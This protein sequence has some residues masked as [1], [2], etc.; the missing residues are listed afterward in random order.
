[1][2]N[3]FFGLALIAT[4]LFFSTYGQDLP[5]NSGTSRVKK[6]SGKPNIPGNFVV[7]LGFNQPF[8][9]D[10][11]FSLGFWGSRTFNAYYQY[12]IRILQSKF[13][14][15]PGIGLSLERFKLKNLHR[16]AYPTVGTEKVL[17]LIPAYEELPEVKKS[18]IVAN[19]IDVPLE[20]RFSTR[21]DDP[22]RS[23]KA[24]VGGRIGYLYDAFNKI[25]YKEEGE[26]KVIKDKQ[27][28]NLS[29]IRYGAFAKVGG[30][31]FSVF[32]YYNFV[33]VFEEGEGP[34]PEKTVMKNFTVG[35]SLSGF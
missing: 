25:K 4:M 6:S 31:N 8:D 19:Y 35:I 33:P 34:L 23:F 24:S 32:A 16:L 22:A 21:P 9:K 10:S 12:D 13:S 1:M 27:N 30:G 11:L 17:S 20:L 2:V 15:V 18:M 5:D 26:T 7:E 14:F 3:K 28:F 29:R